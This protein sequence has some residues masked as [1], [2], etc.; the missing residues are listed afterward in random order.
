[1]V[2][3]VAKRCVAGLYGLSVIK[4]LD[5]DVLIDMLADEFEAM[6]A[7]SGAQALKSWRHIAPICALGRAHA[8]HGRLRDLPP[9][10]RDGKACTSAV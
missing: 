10:P 8:G 1:M 6:V 9:S 2:D 5:I 4:C 3:E 7:T